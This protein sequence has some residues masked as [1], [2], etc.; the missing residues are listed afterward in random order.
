MLGIFSLSMIARH[1]SRSVP[2]IA[3]ITGTLVII[4]M[5][6]SKSAAFPVLLRNP[7]H[8]NMTIVVSALTIYLVGALLG[9]LGKSKY[10][11]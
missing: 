3:V 11:I 2:V 4:W 6:F 7:L 10:E 9:K 1:V 8:T 5:T